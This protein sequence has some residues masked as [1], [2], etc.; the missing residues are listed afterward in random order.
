VAFDAAIRHG[1]ART[2]TAGHP[3]RGQ[4]FLHRQ[5]V[6]LDQVQLRFRPGDDA[7]AQGAGRGPARTPPRPRNS[8]PKPI[9]CRAG[10]SEPGA[11]SRL[12]LVPVTF[13]QAAA[14]VEA[15]H[16]HHGAPA[17]NEFSVGVRLDQRLVGVAIVGRPVA[18]LLD[19]GYTLEVIR[20]ATDGA[21][22]AASKL[23]AAAWRA[24][25]NL[26]Y[27]RMVTYT[28]PDA[29]EAS[30]SLRAAG[31][32]I[33]GI[34]PPRSGWSHPSRPRRDHGADNVARLRWHAST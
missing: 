15:I 6:P 2:A 30:A 22:H 18:R 17:E 5:R 14:F 3:L 7:E 4:F 33:T 11:V 32:R 12:R 8:T 16:R 10:M 26:G 13:A 27:L 21:P 25:R 19:D 28:Q 29:G 9:G 1:S 34:L 31:W 23:Y 24:A 20:L